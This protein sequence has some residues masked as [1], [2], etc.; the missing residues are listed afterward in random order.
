MSKRE[1]LILAIAFLIGAIIGFITS[2]GPTQSM[3]E[4]EKQIWDRRSV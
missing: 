4:R 3:E 1:F 2:S